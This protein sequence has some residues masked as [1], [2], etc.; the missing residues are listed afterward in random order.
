MLPKIVPDIIFTPQVA[1]E[2]VLVSEAK[3]NDWWEPPNIVDGDHG[4]AF[5]TMSRWQMIVPMVVRIQKRRGVLLTLCLFIWVGMETHVDCL[6]VYRNAT[7]FYSI[8]VFCSI[9]L[10]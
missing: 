9:Y 2:V 5:G 7:V 8:S 10:V 1:L 3:R 4:E 6:V